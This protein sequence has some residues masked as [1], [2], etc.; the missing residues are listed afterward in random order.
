PRAR[1]PRPARG[2]FGAAGAGGRRPGRSPARRAPGRGRRTLP[3]DGGDGAGAAGDP[4]RLARRARGGPGP[5]GARPRPA[6]PR[7]RPGDLAPSRAGDGPYPA[8][9]DPASHRGPD[10]MAPPGRPPRPPPGPR[11]GQR[12][13]RPGAARQR[14]G[15]GRPRGRRG[16]RP[17]TPVTPVPRPGVGRHDAVTISH[18]THDALL[19]PPD[20][21]GRP[22]RT[23]QRTTFDAYEERGSDA[24]DEQDHPDTQVA[25]TP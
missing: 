14:V 20:P 7:G 24:Q 22:E 18:L 4:A 1:L 17:V 23:G 11:T 9:G 5:A 12:A 15:A 2:R 19:P 21:G 25:R 13:D 8:D 10:R 3:P 16:P 6:R